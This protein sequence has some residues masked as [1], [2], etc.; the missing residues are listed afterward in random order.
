VIVMRSTGL[1][2]AAPAV[3]VAPAQTTLAVAAPLAVA[4]VDLTTR[5]AA[6]ES[7][8]EPPELVANGQLIRD[9]RLDRYLAAHKQFAGSSALGVPSAFLRSAT[10]EA[11]SR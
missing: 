10:A 11:P 8:S 3:A 7:A 1:A 5:V 9:V 6:T 2:P 4:P